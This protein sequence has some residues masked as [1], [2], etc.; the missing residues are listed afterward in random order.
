VQNTSE[1]ADSREPDPTL[2]VFDTSLVVGGE[3]LELD[4]HL[5]RLSR[6][7]AALYGEAPPADLAERAAVAASGLQLGRLRLELVPTSQRLRLAV[8][9]REVDPADLFPTWECGAELRTVPCAGGLGAHKWV[10]R[11][12]IPALQ[13]GEVPLLLD[14]DEALEAGRANLFAVIEGVLVTPPL[15]GRILPGITRAAAI[16]SAAEAGIEVAERPLSPAELHTAEEVFLTGSIRG[17]EPT[18]SLDD[19]PLPP[20]TEVGRHLATTLRTRW[21]ASS[22][23]T[24]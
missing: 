5:A 9:S 21:L 18:R 2:G 12:R 8:D 15:D 24:P 1:M 11:R 3:P 13:E 14:R 17:I 10:D 16:E 20:P 6:S 4:A 7:A 22:L 19:A 23:A